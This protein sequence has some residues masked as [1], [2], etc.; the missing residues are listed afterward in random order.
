MIRATGNPK[1][2]AT[3][4]GQRSV[5]TAVRFYNKVALADLEAA[6]QARRLPQADPE[7]AS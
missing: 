7:T 6:I 1:L 5:T 2:T 3:F 4:H